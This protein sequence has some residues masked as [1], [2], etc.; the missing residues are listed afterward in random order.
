MSA[1]FDSFKVSVIIPNFNYADFVG[2]AIESILKQTYQNTEIIVVNNGSTDNSL[3]ILRSFGDRILIVDQANLGQSGARNAGLAKSTGELIAFLDADDLWEP[4]KL[5]KQMILLQSDTQLIYS[6]LSR[7]DSQSGLD[8]TIDLPVYS[9]DCAS[10]FLMNPG[11][12]VVLGGESTV[13]FTRE[14]LN[15]VGKFDTTL[16]ISAGWDF[17]RRCSVFTN[18]NY[19]PEVL[20][21]YR[22]HGNNM[23]SNP[24]RR[25]SDNRRAFYKLTADPLS[26][27]CLGEI[28][29]SFV[30]LEWTFVKTYFVQ[31]SYLDCAN[32]ILGFPVRLISLHWYFRRKNLQNN[33]E[34]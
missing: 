18:F 6:G 21:K 31:Q 27:H 20:V 23:S 11:A 9:G 14:L 1:S 28:L 29:V 30:R 8:L 13:L 3:E 15:K 33:A 19:V 5:E 17:F 7:F 2:E 26:S 10:Q 12:A 24:E 25:I 4:K 34:I 22:I 32:E 16:N